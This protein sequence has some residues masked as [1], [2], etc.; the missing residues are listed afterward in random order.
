MMYSPYIEKMENKT[1][2]VE[3]T[4][5]EQ[6]HLMTSKWVGSIFEVRSSNDSWDAIRVIFNKTGWESVTAHLPGFYKYNARV[7]QEC[8]Y[9]YL[10]DALFELK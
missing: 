3:Y 5:N 9:S 6:G 1:Y 4:G 8:D 7:L 10:D 2:I